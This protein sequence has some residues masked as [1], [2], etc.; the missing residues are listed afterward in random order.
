[1]ESL[2][3]QNPV[4]N[5]E[6][7]IFEEEHNEQLKESFFYGYKDRLIKTGCKD[8]IYMT[9]YMKVPLSVKWKLIAQNSMKFSEAFILCATDNYYSPY[10]LQDAEKNIKDAD[11]CITTKGYFYDFNYDKILKYNF[12]SSVGLQMVARTELVRNFPS[13]AVNQGVDMWFARNIGNDILINNDH[14]DSIL[15][16]NGMNNISTERVKFFEDPQPPFF[17]TDKELKDIVP[18][19]IEKRIKLLTT[20]RKSQ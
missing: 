2:C 6:L 15:C 19:D 5:W 14:W 3:R 12:L 18:P 11:W 1:M 20:W 16:T 13:E 10:M 7:I 17:E 8:I 4:D 9:A